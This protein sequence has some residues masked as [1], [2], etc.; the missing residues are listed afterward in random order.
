M[1]VCVCIYAIWMLTFRYVYLQILVA[2][3]TLQDRKACRNAL[4]GACP[5]WTTQTHATLCHPHLVCRHYT[6]YTCIV[7][8]YLLTCI[9]AHVQLLLCRYLGFMCMH[10]SM[11]LS[12]CLHVARHIYKYVHT[13]KYLDMCVCKYI[14]VCVQCH[15]WQ[16]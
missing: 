8:F 14:N 3:P 6:M 11:Y 5:I 13:Y 4:F 9:T 15:F 2:K 16:P 10:M 7:S 1:Y 12:I